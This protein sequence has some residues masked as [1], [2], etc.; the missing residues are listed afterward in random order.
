MTYTEVLSIVL[1]V[2]A[3]VI[4]MISL[5]SSNLS[6]FRLKILNDSPTF[7]IYEITSD[8]D[9][10]KKQTWWIPSFDIGVSFYNLGILSGEIIDF[11]IVANFTG[12]EAIRKYVF[13]PKWVVD[14]SKFH[15]LR[16]KRFEWIEQAINRDWYPLLLA[17]KSE[18]HVHLILED[19]RW[20]EKQVGTMS[21]SLQILS[22]KQKTWKTFRY[23][24][25]S[26]YE[27]IFEGC[28]YTSYD[29]KVMDMRRS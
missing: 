26:F 5:W 19:N 4:S 6:P 1:S 21:I 23:Y 24:K 27:D 15:Q 29:E 22:S 14:Y 2:L 11:R 25:L 12:E 16:P 10:N 9:D 13:Y 7:S 8:T 3:L 17:G 18:T 28:T 20:D